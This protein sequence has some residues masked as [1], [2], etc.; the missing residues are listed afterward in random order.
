MTFFTILFGYLAFTEIYDDTELMLCRPRAYRRE[1]AR[2]VAERRRLGL[3][4]DDKINALQH[5]H[6]VGSGD[7]DDGG[8]DNDSNIGYEILLCGALRKCLYCKSREQGGETWRKK[9]RITLTVFS[10]LTVLCGAVME[11]S[12]R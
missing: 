2:R 12:H 4:V 3:E 1:L 11:L 9:G 10:L 8:S 5:I 6:G 7:R